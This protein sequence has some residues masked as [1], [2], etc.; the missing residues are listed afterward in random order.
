MV[1][2][3]E[4]NTGWR[5]AWAAARCVRSGWLGP[6]RL[7]DQ[8]EREFAEAVGRRYAVAVNSGTAGLVLSLMA[9][10]VGAG[11]TVVFP[12]YG[13]IAGA[14]AARLCGARVRL[15]DVDSENGCM[16]LGVADCEGAKAVVFIDHNGYTGRLRISSREACDDMDVPLIEDACQA[17]GCP[18]AGSQGRLSVFSFSPQK[19]ITTGQGGMVVTDEDGLAEEV[20]GLRDHGGR[21]WR[22]TGIHQAVGGNFRLPDVLAAIG[23][24]QLRRLNTLIERRREILGWYEKHSLPRRA[25]HNVA[26]CAACRSFNPGRLIPALRQAGVEAKRL[27]QPVFRH[28]I[29]RC[30]PSSFPGAD[31]YARETIYLPS[32][33]KMTE[34]RVAYVCEM[35]KCIESLASRGTKH[36]SPT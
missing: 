16:D 22:Q 17:L 12:A 6:G 5:E 31:R 34:K 23:L 27:Y 13:F 4:P 21:D 32:H 14:N 20:A 26:W 11:S 15:V 29:F 18:D 35:V 8:F 9:V 36:R 24:P 33:L 30:N 25:W 3:F 10:G 2:L 28:A 19:L 7:T 1:H